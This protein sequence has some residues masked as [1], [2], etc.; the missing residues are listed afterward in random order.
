MLAEIGYSV[1]CARDGV[2]AIE[3]Y[4]QA[5][6]D[7]EPFDAVV[8]DLTVPAGMGGAECIQRLLEIEPDVR[9]IVSSG[10]STGKIVARFREHGF[11]GFVRKPYTL[12][13][14]ATVLSQVMARRP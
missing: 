9:A 10:Y 2:E 1:A 12:E 3:L 7:G 6:R 8:L 11:R 14:M 5:Q 13:E 4:L